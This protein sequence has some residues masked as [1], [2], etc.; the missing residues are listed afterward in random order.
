VSA[1]IVLDIGANK[2]LAATVTAHSANA[3]GIAPGE[4][5]CALFDAG[6]VIV[7]ID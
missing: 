1:E 3:L 6:H 2:T 7:A 5:A 4:P